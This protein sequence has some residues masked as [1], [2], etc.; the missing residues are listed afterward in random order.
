MASS[1]RPFFCTLFAHVLR[2]L[3]HHQ[4]LHLVE[5]E[6]AVGEKLVYH[7]C[8]SHVVKIRPLGK[9]VLPVL[10]ALD[11]GT[12]GF[13]GVPELVGLVPVWGDPGAVFLLHIKLLESMGF[14]RVG[15]LVEDADGEAPMEDFDDSISIAVVVNRTAMFL[16]LYRWRNIKAANINFSTYPKNILGFSHY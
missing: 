8:V 4:F 9:V 14:I 2:V 7:I 15:M 10:V 12:V 5:S 13:G 1:L 16:H 11:G 6:V 3:F